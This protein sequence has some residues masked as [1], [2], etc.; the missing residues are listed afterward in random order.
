MHV[1]DDQTVIQNFVHWLADTKQHHC[2]FIIDKIAHNQH[3]GILADYGCKFRS[4][5]F[6]CR[7]VV[8]PNFYVFD[9]L[10]PM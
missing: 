7:R 8:R 9:I 2:C 3:V 6:V 5:R 4:R 1:R 10:L